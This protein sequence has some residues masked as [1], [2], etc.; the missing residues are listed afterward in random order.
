METKNLVAKAQT[1]IDTSVDK[2][3][4]ALTDPKMIKEYMFGTTVTSDWEEGS[5]ITWK[6]EMNG[7][8]YEDKGKILEFAPE[9]KLKYSHFSPLSGQPDKPE[10]YH[11]VTITLKEGKDKTDVTLTQN[12]NG[13]E[14][15]KKEAEKNWDAMLGSLKKLLENN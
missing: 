11:D 2:V 14:K 10:N 13:S 6:G 7:K 1:T 5:E 12:R 3:W 9:K 15:E 4:K 8:K